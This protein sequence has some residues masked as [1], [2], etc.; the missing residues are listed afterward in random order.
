M[1][2]VSCTVCD[3]KYN[4]AEICSLSKIKIDATVNHAN[5]CD[6]TECCSFESL[7]S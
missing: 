3:C 5:C 6:D 4:K 1:S 2:E 7:P